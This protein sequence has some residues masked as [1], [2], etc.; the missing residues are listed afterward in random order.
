MHMHE[1]PN[2]ETYQ[3]ILAN[4]EKHLLVR[5]NQIS[6]AIVSRV[7]NQKVTVKSYLIKTAELYCSL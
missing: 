3:T 7:W 4:Q 1:S 2:E 6:N 5:S